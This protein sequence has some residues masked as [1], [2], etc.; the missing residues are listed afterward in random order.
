[1]SIETMERPAGR[2][3][4]GELRARSLVAHGEGE[5]RPRANGAD[6]EC[7]ACHLAGPHLMSGAALSAA[8]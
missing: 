5:H 3:E 6:P 4:V 2:A 1:M 7:P 8:D